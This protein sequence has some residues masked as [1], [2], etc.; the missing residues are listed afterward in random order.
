M[1]YSK[2]GYCGTRADIMTDMID[3]QLQGS[4]KIGIGNLQLVSATNLRGENN[5]Y[6]GRQTIYLASDF[7]YK[8]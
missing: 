7:K 2:K 3:K 6:Y 5:R 8:E 1:K 4:N